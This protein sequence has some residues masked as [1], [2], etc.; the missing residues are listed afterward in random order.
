[1]CVCVHRSHHVLSVL[2]LNMA[3]RVHVLKNNTIFTHV[4]SDQ[5]EQV[6]QLTLASISI[7][8]TLRRVLNELLGGLQALHE[9]NKVF[10]GNCFAI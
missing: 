4:Q 1:M 9:L 5:N 10:V 6:L 7:D 8:E 2:K 3:M